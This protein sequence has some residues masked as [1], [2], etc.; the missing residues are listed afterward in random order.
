MSGDDQTSMLKAEY[1]VSGSR[2]RAQPRGLQV[3]QL[4]G[5]TSYFQCT[6]TTG[7]RRLS[8]A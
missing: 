2:D 7:L 3:Q 8:L 1:L 5:H 4:Y 6:C